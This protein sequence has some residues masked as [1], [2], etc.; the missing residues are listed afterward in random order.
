MLNKIFVETTIH[1]E[2]LFSDAARQAQIEG[3][4]EDAVFST[5]SYVYME[6]RRTM[7]QAMSYVLSMVL[8]MR[9]EGQKDINLVSL[10]RRL[11]AGTA[12]HF[13]VRTFQ[14]VMLIY[15]YLLD[16]FSTLIV[17]TVILIDY[18]EY[19]LN[20]TIPERFFESIDEYINY[21]NCDLVRHGVPVGDYLHRRLSCNARRA[22]CTLVS[23]LQQHQAELQ[24]LELALAAAAPEK[25]NPRTLAA[26]KKINVDILKALGQRT[27][28]HLGDVIIALEAPDDAFLYTTDEHFG[29]ICS[30]LGKQLFL[31][32]EAS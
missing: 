29:L 23:F 4:L 24:K 32:S 27:C 9:Q 6:F 19:N 5:S 12:I 13:S 31:E 25:V 16:H 20:I 10:L 26:L 21:T 8:K 11:S 15:S 17:P 7:L 2:R 18:L 14:R 1:I 28:W 3:N 22:N 30:V